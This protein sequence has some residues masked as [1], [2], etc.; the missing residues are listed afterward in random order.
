MTTTI[1]TTAG[2]EGG[3]TGEAAGATTAGEAGERTAEEA[4]E[5]VGERTAEGVA[6]AGVAEGVEGG[7]PATE[8]ATCSCGYNGTVP[9]DRNAPLLF[10]LTGDPRETTNLA[11]L[12]TLATLPTTRAATTTPHATSTVVRNTVHNT[13]HNTVYAA[14]LRTLRAELDTYINTEVAPLNRLASERKAAPESNP[15][16]HNRTYWAPWN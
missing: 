6:V 12:A 11:T 7:C 8:Y 1:S 3:K 13:V 4:A 14:I 15:S 10:N 2:D 5:G 9:N 16:K